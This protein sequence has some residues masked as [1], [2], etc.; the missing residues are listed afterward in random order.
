MLLVLGAPCQLVVLAG[1]EHG[2]T[3]PLMDFI[4]LDELGYALFAQSGRQLLFHLVSRLYEL[5]PNRVARHPQL[6]DRLTLPRLRSGA[7][8]NDFPFNFAAG[9]KL[10]P[11]FHYAA[12]L[13]E[14]VAPLIGTLRLVTD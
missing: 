3:I 12:P 11:R 13:L 7:H 14:K 2:R 1:P 9:T 8:L 6:K 4:V 10:G 5:S